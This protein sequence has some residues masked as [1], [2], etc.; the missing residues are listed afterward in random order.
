MCRLPR[1][2]QI[3]A[4]AVLFLPAGSPL[5]C[6]A[7]RTA[8]ASITLRAVLEQSLTL[9]ASPAANPGEEFLASGQSRNLPVTVIS[10][11]VLGPARVNV[12][13]LSAPPF[14]FTSGADKKSQLANNETDYDGTIVPQ[15]PPGSRRQQ[16]DGSLTSFLARSQQS[17]RG[18]RID[19][20]TLDI[21]A[22]NIGGVMTIRAQA[23]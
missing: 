12:V 21:P 11:W 13:V 15:P 4:A 9:V 3:F 7:Q 5:P 16:F 2:T 22:Q 10:N 18:S 1:S 23:L 19:T 14:T 8:S 6:C 20:R 17:A